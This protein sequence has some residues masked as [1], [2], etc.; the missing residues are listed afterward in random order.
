MNVSVTEA[1]MGGE[2]ATGRFDG[3]Q[4]WNEK[5]AR[6][7]SAVVTFAQLHASR[8]FEVRAGDLVVADESNGGAI[9]VVL[10]LE[11]QPHIALFDAEPADGADGCFWSFQPSPRKQQGRRRDAS[12]LKPALIYAPA[13]KDLFPVL[14]AVTRGFTKRR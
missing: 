11:W 2:G 14:G 4:G 8:T 3:W 7:P 1:L 12:V 9:S 10:L 13:T 5:R 6:P